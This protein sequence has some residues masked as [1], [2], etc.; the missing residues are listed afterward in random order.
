MLAEHQCVPVFVDDQAYEGHYK[1]FCKQV[2]WPLFHYTMPDIFLLKNADK[3][4]RDYVRVNRAFADV[5]IATYQPGDT[6]ARPKP[7]AAVTKQSIFAS[8]GTRLPPHAAAADASRGAP[9]GAHRLFPPCSLP[10]L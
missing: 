4:W 5:V 8:L 3:P 1:M 2:L 6:S 7:P 10:F 9:A